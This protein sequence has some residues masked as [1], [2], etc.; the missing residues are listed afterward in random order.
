MTNATRAYRHASPSALVDG[1]LELFTSGG[2]AL[3]GPALTPRFFSG[4]QA[5]PATAALPGVADVALAPRAC[6]CEWWWDHW[7]S[8]RPC[9]HMLAAR[10]TARAAVGADRAHVEADR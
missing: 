3:S 1:R 9:K 6:T 8:R 4:A 7:G 2:T 5:A 10:V